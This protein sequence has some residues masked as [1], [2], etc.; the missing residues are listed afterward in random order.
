MLRLEI[1][2]KIGNVSYIDSFLMK[3]GRNNLR[4]LSALELE[5]F[6]KWY[7]NQEFSDNSEY[8]FVVFHYLKEALEY[9]IDIDELATLSLCFKTMPEEYIYRFLKN[10][11]RYIIPLNLNGLTLLKTYLTSRIT[12]K[13]ELINLINLLPESCYFDFD[14]AYRR[15]GEDNLDTLLEYNRKLNTNGKRENF[16]KKVLQTGKMTLEEIKRYFLEVGALVITQVEYFGKLYEEAKDAEEKNKILDAFIDIINCNQNKIDQGIEK[17]EITGGFI[18]SCYEYIYAI[19][20]PI[21]F[22]M[23]MKNQMAR[24]LLNA[25]NYKFMYE[26]LSNIKCSFNYELIDALMLEGKFVVKETLAIIDNNY[27]EYALTKLLTRDKDFISEVIELICNESKLFFDINR[28]D[29]ILGFIYYRYYDFKIS[30]ESAINLINMASKYTPKF[31]NEYDFSESE[32]NDIYEAYEDY[33]S[34]F[35]RI[36]GLYLISGNKEY[37]YSEKDAKAKF[38]ELKAIRKGIKERGKN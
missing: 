5:E 24:K 29:K 14:L 18:P 7:L 37:L 1:L 10:N 3:K 38:A 17:N 13:E 35:I 23:K 22:S 11:N 26:W 8:P 16:T 36:Y 15:L 12:D 30:K 34:D 9:K 4:K 2:K 28:I 32:R 33:E 25:K 20:R 21:K 27:L 19:S 31:M 6:L